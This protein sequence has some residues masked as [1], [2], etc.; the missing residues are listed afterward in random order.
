MGFSQLATE[1]QKLSDPSKPP[2]EAAPAAPAEVP[3]EGA[4]EV[5]LSDPAKVA[6]KPVEAAK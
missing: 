2:A 1:R 6:S 5:D 4:V 3:A